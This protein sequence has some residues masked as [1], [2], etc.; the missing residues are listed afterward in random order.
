MQEVSRQLSV[1][2]HPDAKFIQHC[3][4]EFEKQLSLQYAQGHFDTSSI[5]CASIDFLRD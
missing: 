3:G 1:Q 5:R 4:S 2:G